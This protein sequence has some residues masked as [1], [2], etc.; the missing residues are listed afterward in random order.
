MYQ[1]QWEFLISSQQHNFNNNK[2]FAVFN[3]FFK[4]TATSETYLTH[5]ACVLNIQVDQF[6]KSDTL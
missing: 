5:H 4:T 1:Y 6:D 2:V 3:F